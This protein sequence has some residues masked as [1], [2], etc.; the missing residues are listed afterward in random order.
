MNRDNKRQD[1]EGR[2]RNPLRY[3]N[4]DYSR[5]AGPNYRENEYDRDF[6]G[7]YGTN[8]FDYRES[9]SLTHPGVSGKA[10]NEKGRW[11]NRPEYDQ[12]RNFM[13]KGPKGYKR[14]D[15]RIYEEVCEAL[16]RSHE[17]NATE[18]GVKV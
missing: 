14:T 11:I 4:D 9:G 13:G 6:G 5:Y 12:Q 2:Q 3:E 1:R 8:R 17:V 7:N 15:D 16:M 18:I 10:R